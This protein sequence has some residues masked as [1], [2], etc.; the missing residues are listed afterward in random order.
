MTFVVPFDGSELAETA[1]VRATEFSRVFDDEGVLAVSIIPTDN[2]EYA[3]EHGWIDQNEEFDRESVVSKLHKQVTDLCPIAD[4]RH[5][6]VDRY[7]RSGTISNRIRKV[8]KKENASMVF[9]GSENAG[10]I[11]TSLSSVGGSIAS[12]EAYDVVIVRHRSPA[13]LKKLKYNSPHR[14]PKSDFYHPA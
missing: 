8:A 7:A 9:I 11:V 13:K 12:D 5:K 3:R 1:L 4:F 10:R 2:T 14:K 6:I